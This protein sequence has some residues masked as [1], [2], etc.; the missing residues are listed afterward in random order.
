M[1]LHTPCTLFFPG[2]SYT[3]FTFLCPGTLTSLSHGPWVGKFFLLGKT[4]TVVP[5]GLQ[6]LSPKGEIGVLGYIWPTTFSTSAPIH[7]HGDTFH[8]HLLVCAAWGSVLSE[9]MQMAGLHQIFTR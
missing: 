8:F 1:H 5:K 3:H 6:G 7:H 9:G 2:F 4:L